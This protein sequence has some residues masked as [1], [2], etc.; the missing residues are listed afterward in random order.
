ML[1][2]APSKAALNSVIFAGF[3]AGRFGIATLLLRLIV[4]AAFLFHGMGKTEELDAFARE[5]GVPVAL[6]AV[7]TIGQLIG[8]ILLI[9]GLFTSIGSALIAGTMAVATAKLIERGESFVNPAGHS[10]E[11]SCFYLIAGL[12]IL[13]LGPG[14]YS[15]DSLLFSREQRTSTLDHSN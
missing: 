13:L 9:T 15:I 7:A 4:G 5:F 6:A 8:A 10:W 11:A 14:R 1:F 2:A 3:P 12:A